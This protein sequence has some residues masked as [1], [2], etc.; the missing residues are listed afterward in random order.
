MVIER[1]KKGQAALTDSLFFLLIVVTVCVFLFRYSSTY[2][3]RVQESINDFYFKEYAN[4][5]M[6]SIFYMTV[7][8]DINKNYEYPETDYLMTIIKQDFYYNSRIGPDDDVGDINQMEFND[9]NYI[10]KFHLYNSLKVIMQ[11][12]ENY[13]Y[14]FYISTPDATRPFP[15][16]LLK[17]TIFDLEDIEDFTG[18]AQY[19]VGE[20]FYY[21]CDPDNYEQVRDIFAKAGK[22][23]SSSIP[24]RLQAREADRDASTLFA[25]WPSTV[26]IENDDV[27]KINCKKIDE[28]DNGNN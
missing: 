23:S 3:T 7:P 9:P 6:R 5:A 19:E 16:F 13:D 1:Y 20:T 24:I 28:E 22:I 14:L 8:N 4:S 27:E 26:A 2:G 11:P 17:R 15:F 21:L 10:G 25:L 12:L 18:R